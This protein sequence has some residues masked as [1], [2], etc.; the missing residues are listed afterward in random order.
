VIG[1]SNL[2]EL[3]VNGNA[4]INNDVNN[5]ATFISSLNLSGFTLLNDTTINGILNVSSNSI[6]NNMQYLYHD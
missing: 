5:N 6:F 1:F 2:N 4:I 3:T